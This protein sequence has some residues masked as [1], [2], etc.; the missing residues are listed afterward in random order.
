MN[1]MKLHN[2]NLTQ[3]NEVR[4][5]LLLYG[6]ITKLQAIMSYGIMNLGDVIFKLR[7]VLSIKTVMQINAKNKKRY[8]RYMSEKY[9]N[10]EYSKTEDFKNYKAI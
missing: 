2:K 6:H 10:E 4:G 1:T 3:I 8:A 9:Y 5:H 7:E